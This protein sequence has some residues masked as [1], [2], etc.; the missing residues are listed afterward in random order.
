M[1][2]FS[3]SLLPHRENAQVSPCLQSS[4]CMRAQAARSDKQR[5]VTTAFGFRTLPE[6]AT[7]VLNATNIAIYSDRI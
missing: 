3:T 4:T 2:S 7:F 1:N 6:N 5:V